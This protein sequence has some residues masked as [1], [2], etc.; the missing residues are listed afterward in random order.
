VKAQETR[1]KVEEKK[2]Q[3]T[4]DKVQ[5]TGSKKKRITQLKY[6]NLRTTHHFV[7]QE[8]PEALLPLMR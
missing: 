5:D 4:R 8:T 6:S 3:G 1:N 2:I 7:D